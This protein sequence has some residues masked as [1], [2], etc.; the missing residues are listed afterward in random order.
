MLDHPHTHADL[1]AKDVDDIYGQI[2]GRRKQPAESSNDDDAETKV[3][4]SNIDA[5]INRMN[6]GKIVFLKVLC[7]GLLHHEDD[8]RLD[9]INGA[10]DAGPNDGS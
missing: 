5:E 3:L 6:M 2:L 4:D 1:K 10:R 9:A 7:R 8:I